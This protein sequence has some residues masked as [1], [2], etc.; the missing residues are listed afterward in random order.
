[1]GGRAITFRGGVPDW[2]EVPRRMGGRG[3]KEGGSEKEEV[4]GKEWVKV[5]GKSW[6]GKREGGGEIGGRREWGD[7]MKSWK[8]KMGN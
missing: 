1:M 5:K 6:K 8:G 2:E 4:R 3:R 7:E